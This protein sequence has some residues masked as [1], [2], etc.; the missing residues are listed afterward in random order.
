MERSVISCTKSTDNQRS[1]Y[2]GEERILEVM[3]APEG[4]ALVITYQWDFGREAQVRPLWCSLKE[5]VTAHAKFL[6]QK[7]NLNFH[8]AFGAANFHFTKILVQL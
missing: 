8:G 1:Y 2:A 6:A 5:T 4:V 3:C 7:L